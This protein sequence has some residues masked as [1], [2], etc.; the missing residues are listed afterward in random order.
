MWGEWVIMRGSMRSEYIW[1]NEWM[2]EEER[3][4]T[5]VKSGGENMWMRVNESECKYKGGIYEW[6]YKDKYK[7]VNMWG[8]EWV[9]ECVSVWI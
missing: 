2:N 3:E 8:N 4:W 9:N 5:W 7:Y 1:M 6:E